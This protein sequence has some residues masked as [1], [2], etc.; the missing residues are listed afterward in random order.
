MSGLADGLGFAALSQAL[1]GA[2][3]SDDFS[4]ENLA[5]E[6]LRK[7]LDD[8]TASSLDLAILLRHTLLSEIA[9][10]GE[11]TTVWLPRPVS[12]PIPDAVLQAVGLDI[13]REGRVRAL[14]WR[15][16]WLPASE[17]EPDRLAAAAGL[18]PGA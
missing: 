4:L 3:R 10:H 5:A 16:D 14:S 13:D 6:R 7:A 12:R 9:R 1:A 15:P 11:D 17:P 18:R 8:P 2:R